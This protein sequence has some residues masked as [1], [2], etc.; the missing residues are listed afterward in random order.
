MRVLARLKHS[1]KVSRRQTKFRPRVCGHHVQ[2][3]DFERQ[4]KTHYHGMSDHSG[5]SRRIQIIGRGVTCSVAMTALNGGTAQSKTDEQTHD[6]GDLATP[7]QNGDETGGA[8]EGCRDIFRGPSRRFRSKEIREI[9][10]KVAVITPI[11]MATVGPVPINSA[12]S[13]PTTAKIPR[14]SAS[15]QSRNW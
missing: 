7:A 14:P 12:F 10:P 2:S 8:G 15:N 13:A 1:T 3:R 6:D 9:S 11:A 4:R 5:R